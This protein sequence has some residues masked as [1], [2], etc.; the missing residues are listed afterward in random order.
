MTNQVR[1]KA[2][3]IRLRAVRLEAGLSQEDAA[4]AVKKTRQAVA[5]WESGEAA[6]SAVQ[7]G[8]LA[9]LYGTSTDYLILGMRTVPVS[10]D[11]ACKGCINARGFLQDI[12]RRA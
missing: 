9:A 12:L 11:S 3:G 2:V 4:E 8:R 1:Q 7:L 6:I 5:Q 10:N